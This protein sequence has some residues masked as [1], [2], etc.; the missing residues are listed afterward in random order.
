MT[1]PSGPRR[2]VY[3]VRHGQEDTNRRD[4]ELQ[5]PLSEIGKRQARR[6]AGRLAGK[7]I[8]LIRSSDLLRASQTA[9]TIGRQFPEHP[10][11][12]SKMLRECVPTIPRGRE[13]EPPFD[14]IDPA[15]IP[16]VRERID[17]VFEVALSIPPHPS[18]EVIVAHGNLIRALIVRLLG[19]YDDAWLDMDCRNCSLTTVDVYGDGR[20]V[21]V[22]FNDV[23]HLE[24]DLHTHV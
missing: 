4:G 13:S 22:G 10:V 21:L 15:A 3:L 19:A 5:G 9:A 1:K 6:T 11:Q 7:P 8:S 16:R 17:Q 23:A 2:R 12:E 24:D 14:S 18:H 20:R